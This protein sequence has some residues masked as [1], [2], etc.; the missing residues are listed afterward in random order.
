MISKKPLWVRNLY[1]SLS[2]TGEA[3][4]IL[5]DNNRIRVTYKSGITRSLMFK[6]SNK[7]YN[8]KMII[9]KA[10]SVV[11][12][13]IEVFPE[14]DGLN[15]EVFFH[16]NK[17][18]SKW[19]ELTCDILSN[20]ILK[21][22]MDNGFVMPC[23]T[24]D[25]VS[26]EL[27][28]L[29]LDDKFYL[30]NGFHVNKRARSSMFA[31]LF[32]HCSVEDT[33]NSNGYSVSCAFKDKYRLY[34][35]ISYMVKSGNINYTRLCKILLSRY[36]PKVSNPSVYSEILKKNFN[37]DNRVICDVEPN[38]GENVLIS[39]ITG[40]KY[41]ALRGELPDGVVKSS[42][43]S[44]VNDKTKIDILLVTDRFMGNIKNAMKLVK[45]S[46]NAAVFISG[47][48]FDWAMKE[49]KPRT[50]VSVTTGNGKNDAIF[51]Y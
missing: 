34:A 28:R 50:Y 12:W 51:I 9:S 10:N 44:I 13:P 24:D 16:I 37:M 29:K 8:N 39:Y 41:C 23:V 36:G 25:D 1:D 40:S 32:K 17:E 30:N 5:I 20:H 46:N 26:A 47:R 49:H 31:M 43:V 33:A 19:S 3:D 21:K 45:I 42:G 15:K 14:R 2:R 38:L 4:K 6:K 11:S 48:D 35:A 7:L 27:N 22:V 18:K